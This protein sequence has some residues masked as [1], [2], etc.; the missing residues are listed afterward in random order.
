MSLRIG[1]E[2]DRLDKLIGQ[3]LTL[4]RIESGIEASQRENFDL[5]NLVQEVAV[6]GDFEARAQGREVKVL[7]ADACIMSGVPEMLRSAIENVVRNSIRY[8]PLGTS[9]DLTLEQTSIAGK[10]KALV[11][12]SL[13]AK[14]CE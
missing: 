6:D 5:M 10:M 1:L 13:P 7:H 9:V 4:T 14:T 12:S 8:T 2:A 11:P 3:L